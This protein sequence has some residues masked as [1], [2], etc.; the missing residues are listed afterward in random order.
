MT[1]EQPPPA[2]RRVRR[3]AGF[4]IGLLLLVAAVWALARQG[5]Q[6][7]AAIESAHGASPWLIG[8]ALLLPLANWLL[9]SLSFWILMRRH[10]SVGAGE[11]CCLIGAA[12]LLNYLPFRPGLLGRVAYHKS[13]NGIGVAQSVGV[14]IISIA[15]AGASVALLLTV[16]VIGH[17]RPAPLL[18]ALTIFPPLVLCIGAAASRRA[19]WWLPVTIAI[20]YIDLVVWAARYGVVF[21]IIGHPISPAAM[22]AIACVCQAAMLVPLVGNGLGLREWAVGVCAGALPEGVV[23]ASG[24][25]A[26]AS[27]LAADL[28]NRAAE[29]ITAIPVG[30]G[31]ALVLSRRLRRRSSI[32]VSDVM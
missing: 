14:T 11:M 31:C 6:L 2:R 12:W 27:G 28:V 4:V 30:L 19:R 23:T 25:L 22:G 8:A 9:M 16:A 10:G 24:T 5:D 32:P 21:A 17:G 20:R 1:F 3:L 26:T 18:I 29:V 15:C 13:V 7:R